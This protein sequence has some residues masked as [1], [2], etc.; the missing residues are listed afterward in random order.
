MRNKEQSKLNFEKALARFDFEK[1]HAIMKLLD[2][3]WW[4]DPN[5]PPT[6][7]K[8]ENNARELFK[9]LIES[10]DR[11]HSSGGF[12]IS[13]SDNNAVTIEFIAVESYWYDNL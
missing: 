13:V 11:S 3:T 5:D 12:K 2:W 4:D 7:T 10:G 1:V 8:V 9:N 6:I